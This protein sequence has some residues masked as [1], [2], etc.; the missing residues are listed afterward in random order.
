[1]CK[2]HVT[3]IATKNMPILNKMKRQLRRIRGGDACEPSSSYPCEE[4]IAVGTC[5]ALCKTVKVD[6][7]FDFMGMEYSGVMCGKKS[8]KH[9]HTTCYTHRLS[10]P[11]S[12]TNGASVREVYLDNQLTTKRRI[13]FESSATTRSEFWGCSIDVLQ[14]LQTE[15]PFQAFVY[16]LVNS[17]VPISWDMF[18]NTVGKDRSK[19]LDSL[20]EDS[21]RKDLDAN[22]VIQSLL[23]MTTRPTL[24]EIPNRA[25][26]LP[27][28]RLLVSALEDQTDMVFRLCK[29][30]REKI[31]PSPMGTLSKVRFFMVEWR[32]PDGRP[33]SLQQFKDHEFL[34]SFCFAPATSFKG[35]LKYNNKCASI[36]EE[37]GMDLSDLMFDKWI[38]KFR[39]DCMRRP[40]FPIHLLPR[41]GINTK[42]WE[43]LFTRRYDEMIGFCKK[44]NSYIGSL[45]GTPNTDGEIPMFFLVPHQGDLYIH[46]EYD[47]HRF[48]DE[49]EAIHWSFLTVDEW[50]EAQTRKLLPGPYNTDWDRLGTDSGNL[51]GTCFDLTLYD[52]EDA[53]IYL[54]EN[55]N[56]NIIIMKVRNDGTF[57][58]TCYQR[59][60]LSTSEEFYWCPTESLS[61]IKAG[62]HD[63]LRPIYTSEFTAYV[64]S[65]TASKILKS[66]C[67]YFV[68][69]QTDRTAPFTVSRTALDT[70][71]FVSAD[72]CQAG[73][74]KSIWTVT[75]RDSAT[76]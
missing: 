33:V 71:D 62:P 52:S 66:H 68:L 70:S 48:D 24:D 41:R 56:D 67:K 59:S 2:F 9:P 18:Q 73:T 21:H 28:M 42:H 27:I 11:I 64:T 10:I 45:D 39:L 75:C 15:T 76:K 40:I 58:S 65:Y 69:T 53:N 26:S 38:D 54:N 1:V 32:G 47:H 63:T 35:T 13:L 16:R 17:D 46:L 50:K 55:P 8:R 44:W 34:V 19:I 5:Q 29:L 37:L 43:M 36:L 25:G 3:Y 74:S 7:T 57:F 31:T 12:P 30:L 60:I 61:H 23:S 22:Q 14:H 72:H 51:P 49:R 20:L 6:E 4:C